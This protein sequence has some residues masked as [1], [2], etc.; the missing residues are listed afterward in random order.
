MVYAVSQT[1]L[2][3]APEQCAQPVQVDQHAVSALLIS[4]GKAQLGQVR[5]NHSERADLSNYLDDRA[6]QGHWQA[7]VAGAAQFTTPSAHSNDRLY[8]LP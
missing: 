3:A 1:R 7:N 5:T 4:T 8:R 2:A 6:N